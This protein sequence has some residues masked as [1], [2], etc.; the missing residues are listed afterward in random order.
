MGQPF[1]Y[2]LLKSFSQIPRTILRHKRGYIYSIYVSFI[3]LSQ[4]SVYRLGPWN[5]PAYMCLRP[6]PNNIAD[7]NM[8]PSMNIH[9]FFVRLFQLWWN[10]IHRENYKVPI[11]RQLF[12]WNTYIQG[13]CNNKRLIIPDHVMFWIWYEYDPCQAVC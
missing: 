10:S 3:S 6:F 7:F 9:F 12:C 13:M 1:S 8:A 2:Y 5:L 4:F 11:L